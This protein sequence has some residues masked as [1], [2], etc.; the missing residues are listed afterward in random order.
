VVVLGLLAAQLGC[1]LPVIRDSESLA[2][3]LLP[4]NLAGW[5]LWGFGVGGAPDLGA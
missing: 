5:K 2:T 3:P 1:L 4:V